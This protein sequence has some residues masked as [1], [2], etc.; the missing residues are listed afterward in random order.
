MKSLMMTLLLSGCVSVTDSYCEVYWP[1]KPT[2]EEIDKAL[3]A[4][5]MPLLRRIDRE[6]T[7]YEALDCQ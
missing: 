4:D 7:K 5:L 1:I 6:D 2:N 3:E